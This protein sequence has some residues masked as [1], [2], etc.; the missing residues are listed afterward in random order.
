MRKLILAIHMSVDGF[1]EGP[2][3]DM[4]WM[5]P[6]D[7]EQWDGLFNMLSHVDLFLLGRGM[8][9]DY[10]DHWTRALKEQG[11]SAREVQYAKLASKTPHIVFSNTVQD[12]GWENT[13]VMNG[14]LAPAIK[15]L[16][17][18][19]G[20]DIQVVGGASF[21]SAIIDTGL[22][23]EYRLMIEPAILGKGKRLFDQLQH[24]FE[25][26]LIDSRRLSCGVV[27]TQYRQSARR[28]HADLKSGPRRWQQPVTR[29]EDEKADSFFDGFARPA[30]SALKHAGINSA[31][32]L[33]GYTQKAILA[34]HGI[35]PASLPVLKQKLKDRG[36]DFSKL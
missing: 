23:D 31:E 7:D 20:K 30:A 4:S 6:D 36:L 33:A 24:R 11:F 27:V 34:M 25:L 16:K 1:V 14:P 2:R 29:S 26:S 15:K 13:K 19:P 17:S 12:A 8:W 9:K 10:R 22:V 5:Q 32:Q 3:K 21:S 35:G 28:Q 18:L